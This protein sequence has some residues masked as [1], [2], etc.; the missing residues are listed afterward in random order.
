M[1]KKFG[2]ISIVAVLAL[3]LTAGLAGCG[4]QST[5]ESTS[6]P[7]ASAAPTA[8]PAAAKEILI[9]GAGSSFINPLF[10]KMFS[11]YNK[12]HPN[13]KVNYQSVGS[14]AGQKQLAAGT[15]DFAASD[16]F[17]TDDQIKTVKEGVIHIPMTFGAE[18]ITYNV[19]DTDGKQV[20]KG[21]KLTAD[22]LSGIYL[23]TIKN[24]ND[25]QIMKEN[26]DMKLPNKPINVVHRTDGSGTTAI[27][28]DYL[29]NV[30]DTWK[31]KVGSN[32][33]VSWPVG[34][35]G[36]GNEGVSGL[37]KQTPGSIG[38]VELAYA[39]NNNLP[40]AQ[41]KNAAGKYV[42]PTLEAASLAAGAAPSRIQND[43]TRI[44]LVNMPGD[45]AYPIV[46]Q[47]W[48]LLK[49]KYDDAEMKKAIIDLIKWAYTDGQQY[50]E[51]LLYAKVPDAIVKIN[52]KNIEKVQ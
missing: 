19:Q 32:T 42:Y 2:K 11:E 40:Y 16:A 20:E 15:I 13:V 27:F 38:Y 3:S 37:V 36:K 12:L 17:M 29:S 35:G 26:P 5:A 34:D 14:G 49:G 43:D 52:D 47:T 9:N 4:K 24:W 7:S 25:P 51:A 41:M 6:T 28:T 23:G 48:V 33:S 39:V 46:G 50:S 30:N 22:T 10:Q 31:T 44:S 18:A 45:A 1:F 21:L 8:T